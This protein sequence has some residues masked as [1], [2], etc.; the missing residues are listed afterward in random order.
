[1]SDATD[2]KSPLEEHQATI[3][4]LEPDV[5]SIFAGTASASIAISL[6]RIADGLDKIEI[7]LENL[8]LWR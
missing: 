3:D 7:E 1:M 2:R 6:K 5:A 8:R 4:R